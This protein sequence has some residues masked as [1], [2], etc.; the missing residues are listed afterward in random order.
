MGIET[1][2]SNQGQGRTLSLG[3]LNPIPTPTPAPAAPSMLQL[4]KGDQLVLMK[5]NGAVEQVRL[6]S[7]WDPN[8]MPGQTWDIDITAIIL[9]EYGKT[10][11]GKFVCFDKRFRLTVE[12]GISHNGDNLTGQG[13]G[14]DESIDI[15]LTR[16]A[17]ED[18]KVK[19]FAHIFEAGVK[20]QHFGLVQNAFIQ[21]DE[22]NT[23]AQLARF[24]LTDNYSDFTAIEFGEL[25]REIENTWRFNATGVGL[26]EECIETINRFL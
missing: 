18:M 1:G 23:N 12:G 13:D 9:D 8:P 15:L 24:N 17:P 20:R 2:V 7:G 3:G 4:T 11:M 19:F 26:N 5:S 14:V 16:L 25:E 6:G 21:L 22:I 10:R